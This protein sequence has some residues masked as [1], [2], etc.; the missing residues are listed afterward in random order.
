MLLINEA[1]KNEALEIV[2]GESIG[3]IIKVNLYEINVIMALPYK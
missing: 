1:T 2:L 3:S